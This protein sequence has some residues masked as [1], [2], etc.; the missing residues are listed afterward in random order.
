MKAAMMLVLCGLRE[1][2]GKTPTEQADAAET[3]SL[4]TVSKVSTIL[5]SALALAMFLSTPARSLSPG[6]VERV[7]GV[8][9]QL[10]GDLGDLAY[11]EEA[12]DIWYDEDAAYERRIAA[13]GFSQESWRD[14]LDRTVKGYLATLDQA[15]I[16]AA[17]V[18]A[19]DFEARSDLSEAQKVAAREMIAEWRAKM[20]NWRK[21]GADDAKLVRPFAVRIGRVL[22]GSGGG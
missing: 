11:D 13:A 17:L 2:R 3:R 8:M 5:F 9:E 20:T 16:D 7:V 15:R 14:A 19:L 6:D 1:G 18:P 21:E 10:A 4:V 22:E 12:A